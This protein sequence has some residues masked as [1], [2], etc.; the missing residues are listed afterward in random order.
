LLQ[1]P[2]VT[3]GRAWQSPAWING[4][5]LIDFKQEWHKRCDDGEFSL[6]VY[7]QLSLYIFCSN[8]GHSLQPRRL[9]SRPIGSGL[10]ISS[11]QFLSVVF[12]KDS[13]QQS[14]PLTEKQL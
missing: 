8:I 5:D 13:H 1:P 9:V 10:G 4:A 2:I 12:P 6:S 7:Y 3:G 11:V 14:Q